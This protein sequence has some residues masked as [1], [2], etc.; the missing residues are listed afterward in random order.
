MKRKILI[1]VA[2]VVLI[3]GVLI[4]L[5]F[6]YKDK[7][8]TVV[9][10]T[11]NNQVNARID[12]AD[13]NLSVFRHFPK[14]TLRLQGLRVTGND[15]FAQDTIFSAG[16]VSTTISL[17]ELL[18]SRELELT[19]L[20]VENPRILLISDKAGKVNWNIA[21][22]SS[23]TAVVPSEASSGTFKMKLNDIQVENLNLRYC[24]EAMPMNVWVKNTNL[25]SSGKVAGSMT[26]FKMEA[27]AGEFIFEYDS[28]QYISKTSLKAETLLKADMDKMKFGFDQ[29]KL[30]INHLPL[31]IEGW[32][33]MPDDSMRFDLSFH[34]EKSDFATIL[35]LVP[36]DFQKYLSKADIKGS[37]DFKGSVKGVYADEIY[38]AIDVRL[39]ASDASFKYQDL[40]ESIQ[41]IQISAQITKPE[42][43]LNLLK[44]NVDRAHASVRNNPVDLQLQLSDLMTDPN[45]SG[46]FSGT[47][48]F[49]S[50]KQALPLDSLDLTGI[51]KVNLQLA[52]RMSS[53]EKKQYEKFQSNGEASLLNFKIVSNQLT[54]PVEVK[55]AQV[56][57]NT[58]QI[59]VQRF[60]GTIGQSDFSIQGKVG[61]YLAYLFRNDVLTGNFNL[62]SGFLNL[63]ELSN[64]QR[65]AKP[66]KDMSSA[67]KQIAQ[68][69]PDS[70]VAFQVP[71]KLDMSFQSQVQ[72]A[73][74]DRMPIS[75]I[76]G[77]VRL[78][79]RSLNLTGLTMNMLDG[80]VAMNG[81]YTSNA[82][83]NPLFDFKFDMRAIDLPTAYQ[84]LTTFQRYA[85][86]SSY[87]QGKVSM[88]FSL[89]GVM[90]QSMEIVPVS[91]NGDG[92]LNT[93]NL[94]IAGSPVFDQIRGMIKK[95][96]LKNIKIDDFTAK[97]Q[98]ENGALKLNPFSTRVADQQ[99]TVSGSLSA[100]LKMNLKLDFLVNRD[101]LGTDINKGLSLLPGSENIKMVEASVILNGPISKPE[102]SLDL[103]KARAQIEEEVK[104]ASKEQ[105]KN[106]VK[107]IGDELKKLFK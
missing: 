95:E 14:V 2:I 8:L 38:P 1:I 24:D 35:A 93:Q 74:Y 42:G 3:F 65:P 78:K 5:P 52:G 22:P 67:E 66:S 94:M 62:T 28:V 37:A 73:L 39:V 29:G 16:S 30:W 69:K 40:P 50:L 57:M 6:F 12:F 103:S 46:A 31:Q 21:K 25:S 11:L 54:R 82:T 32:F 104:K 68:A 97:F 36:A 90:N 106:S 99:A 53:I 75:N 26:D 86:I 89:S 72:R 19:S 48:D 18:N 80:T 44:V 55:N 87:S 9:K 77:L 102:V 63:T 70:V 27:R 98:F 64:L 10:N 47:I 61:N 107:K 92:L 101:D 100:D 49:A 81:S 71:D 41:D 59:E 17:G 85:P 4:A 76:Q 56:K 79:N 45:I 96:K 15:E 23:G 91:L 60:S 20:V 58:S 51:L 83:N 7:L 105:I 43:E 34:S 84:S 88:Q 13:F 33:A